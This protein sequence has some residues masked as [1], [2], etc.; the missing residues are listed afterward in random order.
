MYFLLLFYL[1][2]SFTPPKICHLTSWLGTNHLVKCMKYTKGGKYLAMQL[3]EGQMSQQ[4]LDAL[5]S[6][7]V[8]KYSLKELLLLQ[9]LS[10]GESYF[11]LF[12]S[13][14]L[15]DEQLISSG[16]L[17]MKTDILMV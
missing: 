4:L 3:L 10:S 11:W 2:N 17:N 14:C 8:P 9:T 13:K 1:V 7:A 16:I 6:A 12:N 15:V 5:L